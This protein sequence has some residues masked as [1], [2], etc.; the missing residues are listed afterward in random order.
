L[1]PQDNSKKLIRPNAQDVNQ[2]LNFETDNETDIDTDADSIFSRQTSRDDVMDFEDEDDVDLNNSGDH[3]VR[4]GGGETDK[5]K[6][7]QRGEFNLAFSCSH[8][9]RHS[10]ISYFAKKQ[11]IRLFYTFSCPRPGQVRRHPD[12]RPPTSPPLRLRLRDPSA[13]E[14]VQPAAT[15]SARAEGGPHAAADNAQSASIRARDWARGAEDDLP[16]I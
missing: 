6:G 5:K 13:R 14:R 16:K 8:F 2:M 9:F 4:G 15:A 1:N 3:R 10:Q 11:L 7:V 12:H